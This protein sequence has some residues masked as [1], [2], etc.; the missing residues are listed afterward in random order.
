MKCIECGGK[1][2]IK[3][4]PF[5][6]FGEKLGE[7]EAEVCTKCN[8]EVFSE[9]TVRKM[10]DMAKEKGLWGLRAKTKVGVTGNCLDVRINKAI[11]DFVG[12]KKGNDVIIYPEDKKKLV[13][14]LA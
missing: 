5:S 6:L 1:V 10:E 2:V 4:V 14:S 12:L 13:I 11:A 7:F 9:E 8:E 3:K